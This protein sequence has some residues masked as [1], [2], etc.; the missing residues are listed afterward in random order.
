MY[1]VS[2]KLGKKYFKCTCRD[3]K[4]SEVGMYGDKTHDGHIVRVK[5]H[6]TKHR[7]KTL[8]EYNKMSAEEKIVWMNG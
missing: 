3:K 8:D 6:P 4:Y 2:A 1:G 7:V 5:A